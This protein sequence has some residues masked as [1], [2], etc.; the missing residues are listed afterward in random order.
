M[1]V[2]RTFLFSDIEGSTQK[3]E[4]HPALMAHAL[5]RHD[6][7]MT[8]AVARNSGSIVS[9]T[10]DGVWRCSTL[11]PTPCRPPMRPSTGSPTSS[12]RRSNR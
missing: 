5:A 9:H 4:A 10:G 3:W 8:A 12:R 11:P 1:G 2:D 6:E 7:L